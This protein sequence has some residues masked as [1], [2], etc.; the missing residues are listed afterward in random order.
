MAWWYAWT[1][2]LLYMSPY[3]YSAIGIGISIGVSVLGASWY[4]PNTALDDAQNVLICSRGLIEEI[5]GLLEVVDDVLCE[6]SM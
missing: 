2:A 1:H 3:V 4:A 6:R 5:C